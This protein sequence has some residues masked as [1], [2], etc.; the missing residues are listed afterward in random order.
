MKKDKIYKFGLLLLVPVFLIYI[1]YEIHNIESYKAIVEINDKSNTEIEEL[2]NSKKRIEISNGLTYDELVAKINKN[3]GGVLAG[4]GKFIV[5][6]CLSLNIDPLFITAVMVVE[7]GCS[8]NCSYIARNNYNF[9]GIKGSN[10][11]YM[12]Y[13][14]VEE[15]IDGLINVLYYGYISKGAR[16]PESI[17]PRYAGGSTTWASS[18]RYIMNRIKYS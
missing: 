17:A 9:G 4:K 11:T 1:L 5:D 18:V 3:I 15:G 10:G 13:K 12:K 2:V 16:T 14:S 8:S 6:K 7:S